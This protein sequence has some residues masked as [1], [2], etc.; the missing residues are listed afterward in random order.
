MNHKI[1]FLIKSQLPEFIGNEFPR[2]VDFLKAYY[3][4]LE[5]DYL[6]RIESIR[7]I[8]LTSSTLLTFLKQE[9]ASRYPSAKIDD[10]KLISLIRRI[11]NAK[12][13]LDA[14]ELLFRIFFNEAISITQPNKN[15]LRA[16]DGKWFKL[17]SIVSRTTYGSIDFNKDN[18]LKI[19]NNQGV[20]YVQVDTAEDIG[21]GQTRFFYRSFTRVIIEDNQIVDIIDASG[22]ITYRGIAVKSPAKIRVLSGGKYFKLG[23]VIRFPGSEKDTIARVTKLGIDDAVLELEIVEFG[24]SHPENQ[25]II[26]SPFPNKPTGSSYDIVSSVTGYDSPNDKFIYSHLLTVDDF[27]DGI[28]ETQIGV[29]DALTE[30][31]YFLENY[32]ELGYVGN[33]VLSY[34]SF[35]NNNNTTSVLIDPDV[36]IEKW[37]ESRATLS[38]TYD[39]LVSYV[40]E[41]KTN[42]SIISDSEIRLQDNYFYQLFSYVISCSR[43]IKEYRNAVNQI[44]PAGLKLFGEYALTANLLAY[45]EYSVYRTLSEG[46]S[47]IDDSFSVLDQRITEFIKESDAE[48]V[49]TN[50]NLTGFSIVTNLTELSNIID[51]IDSLI[52][53]SEQTDIITPTD[54][55]FVGGQNLL[56][57]SSLID[58]SLIQINNVKNISDVTAASDDLI[59]N[60]NSNISENSNITDT[61][62]NLE[63]VIY[64]NTSYF[65]EDYVLPELILTVG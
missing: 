9:F 25:T 2:F 63:T 36:T 55:I 8:D 59:F 45:P 56:D 49:Q 30:E 54:E 16:S 24:G 62:N 48:L 13:T 38:F 1:A 27:T 22:N 29:S 23:Q 41:Y 47:Y 43:Q 15:I 53:T 33:Q 35:V 40:G 65:A 5:T 39:Y 64:N 19:E 26:V 44:H 6:F 37:L 21:N 11:Y 3:N 4:F 52:S 14:I 28:T 51:S 31:S 34:Q 12:G 58:D 32:A 61:G 50:D 60:I 42:D 57:D 46:Q 20:F 10:R 7:D 17:N 18:L